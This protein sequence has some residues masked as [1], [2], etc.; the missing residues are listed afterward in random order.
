[1][2][3]KIIKISDGRVY[4]CT[5]C[6]YRNRETGFCGFCMRKILDDMKKKTEK[7]ESGDG[8]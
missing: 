8:V 5:D 3:N 7:E 4:H 6:P 2:N 1:M